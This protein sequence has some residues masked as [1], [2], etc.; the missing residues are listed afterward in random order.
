MTGQNSNTAESKKPFI[1]HDHICGMVPFRIAKDLDLN[2]TQ[3]RIYIFI[4]GLKFQMEGV[5]VT[6]E[7]LCTQLG[8]K[9]ESK[10]LQKYMR[11]MKKKGYLRR[12]KKGV[13]R[14]GKKFKAWCWDI[15]SPIILSDK[16]NQEE[17]F[18]G[19]T[20]DD[21]NDERGVLPEHVGGVPPEHLN[22]RKKIKENN[23]SESGDSPDVIQDDKSISNIE[24]IDAFIQIFPNHPHP[25]IKK[26]DSALVINLNKLRKSWAKEI[27]GSGKNLTLKTF[28]N[29]LK[30]M[31]D[32]KHYMT[33]PNKN[34]EMVSFITLKTVK[35]V[36]AMVEAKQRRSNYD[37]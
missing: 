17:V 11:E 20:F 4:A 31:I 33:D 34:Y 23:I 19:N 1:F 28:T 21:N 30:N 3:L 9:E 14:N 25:D 26:P 12:E 16:V 32:I 29:Y 13:E 7:D 37:C 24:M 6:N 22:K 8:I 27:S 5:Y 2:A 10:M 36:K 18:S 35:S 15:G